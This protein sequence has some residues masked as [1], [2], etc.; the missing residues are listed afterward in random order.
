[1]KIEE[2][3]LREL[4]IKTL[5][6]MLDNENLSIAQISKNASIGM[7]SIKRSHIVNLLKIFNGNGIASR[8]KTGRVVLHNLTT[9]GYEIATKIRLIEKTLGGANG[10]E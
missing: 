1:M 2:R 8:E 6:V 4:P 5:L 3:L 9:K 7:N 10:Q